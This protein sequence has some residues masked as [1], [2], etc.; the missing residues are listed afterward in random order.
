MT[1]EAAET[2][3]LQYYTIQFYLQKY[4]CVFM[5]LCLQLQVCVQ[6]FV[7]MGAGV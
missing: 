2:E 1:V 6:L 3:K 7:F 5:C 4:E